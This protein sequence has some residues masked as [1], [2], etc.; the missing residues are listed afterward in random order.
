M[1]EISKHDQN[2]LS[3]SYGELDG[4]GLIDDKSMLLV[5]QVKLLQGLSP[6]V[7][8]PDRGLRAGQ[9]HCDAMDI[10]WEYDQG[11][12]AVPVRVWHR[13]VEWPP[14]S[15]D[16]ST[17]GGQPIHEYLP[18]DPMIRKVLSTGEFGN[19]Q[20]DE[21]NALVDTFY[22]ALVILDDDG[23]P[24][25]WTAFM[26]FARTAIKPFR[27]WYSRMATF[28]VKTPRGK[29]RP[30]L[31]AHQIL[32]KS[33]LKKNPAGQ[34]YFVPMITPLFQSRQASLLRPDSETFKVAVEAADM[35]ASE[36]AQIRY[37]ADH[38]EERQEK[39]D[40]SVF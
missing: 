15:A 19:Y 36:S 17:S 5:P 29:Q 40:D 22:M 18:D 9:Y 16:G 37:D 7:I 14:R 11:V 39:S 13:W 23:N 24:Y 28:T 27:A 20:T 1:E 25:P 6:A 33:S 21:G 12:R 30:P 38:E 10:S 3:Y 4:Q 32:L 26:A 2:T 31:F 35:V 34:S 8:D